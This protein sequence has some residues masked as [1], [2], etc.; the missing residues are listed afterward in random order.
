MARDDMTI[1]NPPVTE[2]SGTAVLVTLDPPGPV[3]ELMVAV[4]PGA[5]TLPDEVDRT[6]EVPMTAAGVALKSN[7]QS[8]LEVLSLPTDKDGWVISPGDALDNLELP[9]P[10]R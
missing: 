6:E 8:G 5:P 7:A 1:S 4:P 9:R 2:M 3:D 10:G